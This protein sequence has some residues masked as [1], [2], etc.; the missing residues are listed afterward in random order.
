MAIQHGFALHFTP[1]SQVLVIG[2]DFRAGQYFPKS[3]QRKTISSN[4]GKCRNVKA[5][6][7][8][9]PKQTVLRCSS[10]G[11]HLRLLKGSALQLV[12]LIICCET[13]CSLPLDQKTIKSYSSKV[14]WEDSLK[15][16]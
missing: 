10:K 7:K 2:L 11:H 5:K 8:T 1:N 9:N 14:I 4:K 3:A 6:K 16:N 12:K 15:G 13:V